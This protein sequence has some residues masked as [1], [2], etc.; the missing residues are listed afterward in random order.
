MNPPPQREDA[1]AGVERD[2]VVDNQLLQVVGDIDDHGKGAALQPTLLCLVAERRQKLALVV[3]PLAE[4]VQPLV[5]PLAECERDDE[6][7]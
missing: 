2:K 4:W 6:L 3:Q 1:L 7:N 5:Q